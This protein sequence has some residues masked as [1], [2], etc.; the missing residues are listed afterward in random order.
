MQDDLR[1]RRGRYAMAVGRLRAGGAAEDADR[2]LGSIAAALEQEH[3]KFNAAWGTRVVSLEE[4]VTGKARP[5]LLLLAG[6]IASVL[7]IA[8]L[9]VANLRLGQVLARRTELAVRTALGASRARIIRSR[10]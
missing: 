6:A 9:N 1:V 10:G 4:Q 5:V 7:L 3:P 2:E 8:C